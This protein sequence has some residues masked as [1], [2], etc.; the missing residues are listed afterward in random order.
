MTIIQPVLTRRAT[1]AALGTLALA[2][3]GG[4]KG[5][6]TVHLALSAQA[7]VNP[8]PDG[9]ERPLILQVLQLRGTAAFDA[10]DALA[11]QDPASALGAD[12]VKAE[13]VTLAPGGS[14][15]KAL[16]LDPATTAI[17]IVAGYRVPAGKI[18]RVKAAV[19]PDGKTS[20]TVTAGP[21]GVVMTPVV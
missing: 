5:P 15:E 14:A 16:V 1:L 11:L 3:C 7:G 19:P 12:L 6:G 20:F 8:G 4:P 13:A 10:A 17:G 9:S 21:T 18:S 2:A